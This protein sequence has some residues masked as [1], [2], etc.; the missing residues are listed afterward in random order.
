MLSFIIKGNNANIRHWDQDVLI[1]HSDGKY[2]LK[3][4]TEISR[5]FVNGIVMS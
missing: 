3:I 1:R 4:D 2:I 5:Y